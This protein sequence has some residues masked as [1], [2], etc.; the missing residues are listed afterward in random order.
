MKNRLSIFIGALLIG[1]PLFGQQT[2]SISGTV[3]GP[4]GGALPGV[5]VEARGDVLP[6]ARTEP[7]ASN[8][9]PRVATK[10]T[11]VSTAFPLRYK[12]SGS[13]F[14]RTPS[15]TSPCN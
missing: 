6:R 8:F 4:E 14:S 12:N 7:T 11:S 15:S 5:T 13:C 2:G 3:T 10:F 1:A 9:Y